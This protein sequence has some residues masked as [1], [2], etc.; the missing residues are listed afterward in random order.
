MKTTSQP[1]PPAVTRPAGT[2]PPPGDARPAGRGPHRPWRRR[3]ADQ[4]TAYA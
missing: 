1:A 3:I 2:A 4:A